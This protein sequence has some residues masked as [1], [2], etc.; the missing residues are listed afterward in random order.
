MLHPDE[1]FSAVSRA[2][3][4]AA[5][6]TFAQAH[7]CVVGI[8]GVGSWVAEA[9][10]RSGIGAITLIDHDDIAIS[11][12]NRQIHALSDTLERSKVEVMAERIAAINPRCECIAID[13]MLVANNID[14]YIDTRFHY[15]IDA[16][17]TVKSKVTL[18]YHCKR[19]RIPVITVG[20]AG[21]RTDPTRIAITDL[22]K[23]SNDALASSVRK[24]LRSKYGWS[25]NP[26]RRFGVECVYS[27][28]QP[29]YPQGD[30]TI[31]Q[32]KPSTAGVTLDCNTGYGSVVG[33]TAVYGMVAASRVL[34]KLSAGR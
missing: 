11:N 16:I 3:G 30:G 9:L 14:K 5:S 7:C 18:I 19:N 4:E 28:Q 32:N 25:R 8:G 33:V 13:D 6:N 15:V 20:G 23:T 22:N 24:R 29:L 2:Y 26:S 34:D 27:D 17:D 10:A 21:G 31:A 1:R 12:I